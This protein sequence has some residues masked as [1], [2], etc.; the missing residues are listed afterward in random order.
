MVLTRYDLAALRGFL[1]DHER[2][3]VPSVLDR[4]RS[5]EIVVDALEAMS[6]TGAV[7]R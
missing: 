6:G 5:S 3:R 2:Y 4:F 7:T 1:E